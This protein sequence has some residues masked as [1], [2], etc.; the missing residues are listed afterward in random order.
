MRIVTRLVVPG[1]AGSLSLCIPAAGQ[2]IVKP[3]T[4]IIPQGPLAPKSA[5]LQQA[6]FNVV[7]R[8]G[9]TLRVDPAGPGRS[10]VYF[11]PARKLP[12][13]LGAGLEPGQCSPA[14]R[15][16]A[17]EEPPGIQFTDRPGEESIAAHRADS[18]R[19]W[20]FAVVKATGYFEARTY[21]RTLVVEPAGGVTTKAVTAND[22]VAKKADGASPKDTAGKPDSALPPR[23]ADRQGLNPQP[24]PPR[25]GDREALNPQPLPPKAT[26]PTAIVQ[27]APVKAVPNSVDRA[28]AKPAERVEKVMGSP[29]PPPPPHRQPTIVSPAIPI[30][31]RAR[32]L[33]NDEK[34]QQKTTAILCR[35]GAELRVDEVGNGRYALYFQKSDQLPGRYSTAL[36]EGRCSPLDRLFDVSEPP[37]IQFVDAL[38]EVKRD[39]AKPDHYWRFEAVQT[40]YGYFDARSHQ[41]VLEVK[42]AVD[43]SGNLESMVRVTPGVTS[44]EI[45]VSAPPDAQVFVQL[46]QEGPVSTAQSVSY[47]SPPL[48]AVGGSIGL[49]RLEPVE[50][51]SG[52]RTNEHVFSSR[53]AG[54]DLQPATRYYYALGSNG[55]VRTQHGSF[56][57]LAAIMT[58]SNAAAAASGGTPSPPSGSGD[59]GIIVVGGR[60]PAGEQ[61]AAARLTQED[62]NKGLPGPP[63]AQAVSRPAE[64]VDLSLQQ[65]SS[66]RVPPK[67]ATSEL[68]EEAYKSPTDRLIHKQEPRIQQWR[69]TPSS[70]GATFEGITEGAESELPFV[71]IGLGRPAP[72][73]NGYLAFDRAVARIAM[74][75]TSEPVSA[76]GWFPN[77]AMPPKY[78][79]RYRTTIDGSLIP[80]TLYHY[81]ITLPRGAASDQEYGTFTTLAGPIPSRTA[82]SDDLVAAP[83]PAPP[84]RRSDTALLSGNITSTGS[85]S[86]AQLSTRESLARVRPSSSGASFTHG[87][88]PGEDAYYRMRVQVSANAA[89]VTAAGLLAFERPLA[90]IAGSAKVETPRLGPRTYAVEVQVD[91]LSPATRYY[92]IVTLS[93]LRGAF[94]Q[95]RGTFTTLPR[96]E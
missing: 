58:G 27:Q 96:Q 65:L 25:P 66:A 3:G 24:L 35:G 20:Q 79:T 34:L 81:V 92:Y 62:I 93:N 77:P 36:K 53:K 61:A 60:D 19:Y 28:P 8:G 57:T 49:H 85:A 39:K 55:A 75:A 76:G 31:G 4:Q 56:T 89:S 13:A 26:E 11:L 63:P 90:D 30:A 42:G 9:P 6:T 67:T 52:G 14:N 64:Q 41:R 44:V 15:L 33:T 47:N 50:G 68:N 29:G 71:E 17:A 5:A 32:S 43:A 45:R 95:E 7:C 2:S 40:N 72:G 74:T 38:G 82:R 69:V 18:N 22:S 54:I 21:Q 84:L 37:G 73:A 16:F 1:L 86:P 10:A 59:R 94:H 46:Y 91:R 87:G 48:G 83:P 23:P 51:T 88:V 12:G 78:V 80:S 70:Q